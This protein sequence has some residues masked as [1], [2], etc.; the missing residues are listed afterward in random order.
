MDVVPAAAPPVSA[1]RTLGEHA[2]A[3]AVGMT[4]LALVLDLPHRDLDVPLHYDGDALFYLLV[5]KG[6]TDNGSPYHIP[7]VGAPF[8]LD[9]HD[10]VN[11]PPV[12][13]L[14]LRVLILLGVSAPAA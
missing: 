1:R 9:L 12:H 7:Q 3:L 11:F 6:M 5:A 13:V 14:L 8:A 2:L 4:L 10:F